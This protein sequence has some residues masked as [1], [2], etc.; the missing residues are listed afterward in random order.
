MSSFWKFYIFRKFMKFQRILTVI[1]T[2]DYLDNGLHPPSAIPVRNKDQF[3]S[4]KS[5][6]SV[7]LNHCSS[8]GSIIVKCTSSSVIL[9]MTRV[10]ENRS[11]FPNVVL[12][13]EC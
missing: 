5:V 8:T 11:I 10:D 7:I 1:H 12:Y 4:I 3:P 6:Y 13:S 9:N 2:L